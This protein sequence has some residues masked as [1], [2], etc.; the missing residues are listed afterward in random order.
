MIPGADQ[1]GMPVSLQSRFF[2]FVSD[3]N[4]NTFYARFNTG[5]VTIAWQEEMLETKVFDDLNV[6]GEGQ[7]LPPDL[8][9]NFMPEPEPK[10]CFPYLFKR[11]RRQPAPQDGGGML[12][13]G[14]VRAPASKREQQLQQLEQHTAAAV[15]T[16]KKTS[17]RYAKI[18]NHNSPIYDCELVA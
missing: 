10:G 13:K 3:A 2:L 6:F 15:S 14:L 16:A 11:L 7:T 5:A 1:I 9:L 4:D 17:S 18:L 12:P 8:D